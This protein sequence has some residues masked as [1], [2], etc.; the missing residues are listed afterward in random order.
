MGTPRIAIS[1][2]IRCGPA[3]RVMMVMPRGMSMPP[4][5]PCSTRKPMSISMVCADAQSTEPRVNSSSAVM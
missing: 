5:R 1:R 3:A 4:P 2:P